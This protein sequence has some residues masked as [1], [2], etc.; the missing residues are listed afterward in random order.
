MIPTNDPG[1]W[2]EE[3]RPGYVRYRNVYGLNWEVHGVCDHRRFCMVGA[4][5]DGVLIETVEQARALPVPALDCPVG[6]GF[7]GCCPLDVTVL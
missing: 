5:V 3:K 1:T 4:V 2:I 7:H 6:P